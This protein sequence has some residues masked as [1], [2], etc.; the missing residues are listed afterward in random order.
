MMTPQQNLLHLKNDLYI[1]N[2]TILTKKSNF[3]FAVS[4]VSST[5]I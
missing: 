5:Y 4:L 2:T 3:A 1:M